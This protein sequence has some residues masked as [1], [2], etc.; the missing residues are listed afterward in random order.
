MSQCFTATATVQV[1]QKLKIASQ[2]V[3]AIRNIDVFEQL[4]V[5][6]IY[7]VVKKKLA[8]GMTKNI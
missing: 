7:K 8:K 2:A 3:Y 4:S 5:K 1:K 6:V